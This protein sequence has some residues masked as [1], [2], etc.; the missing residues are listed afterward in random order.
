M[1]LILIRHTE[2]IGNYEKKY[3]GWSESDLTDK[4][5]DDI[6][7]VE[8]L[9]KSLEVDKIYSSP[10]KRT[11]L[12]ANRLSLL[13]KTEVET[14]EDLR[15]L[16]FGI[17]ENKTYKELLDLYPIEIKKWS[18]DYVNYVIPKGE[19][20][21]SMHKRV[22]RFINNLANKGDGT[23]IIVSHGGTIQ[24]IITHILDLKIEDRWKFKIN[25]GTL[26]ELEYKNGYGILKE[27]IHLS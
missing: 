6:K 10:S 16:N 9:I 11:M 27:I 12:I 18:D 26:V 4:G 24:S 3:I 19:N 22:I 8:E 17:F 5:I 2:S 15:E 14:K 21:F 1:K 20:L 13:L 25:N 23:Y 7:K